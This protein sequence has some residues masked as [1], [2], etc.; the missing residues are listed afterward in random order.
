MYP[1]DR[2]GLGRRGA[3]ANTHA[4]QMGKSFFGSFFSK[5]ELPPCFDYFHLLK[6]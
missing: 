4:R 3:V 5:K 6:K 1:V 2:S